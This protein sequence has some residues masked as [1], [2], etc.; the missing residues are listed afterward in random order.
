MAEHNMEILHET[1]N[2]C[3]ANSLREF[4]GQKI[5]TETLKGLQKMYHSKNY[6]VVFQV[7]SKAF[8]NIY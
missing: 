4:L 7:I 2:N 5:K 1:Y 3:G 8:N 6:R